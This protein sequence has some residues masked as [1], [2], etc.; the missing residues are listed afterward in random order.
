MTVVGEY[1][2]PSPELPQ[3]GV[4][5]FQADRAPGGLANVGH[6]VGR[7]DGVAPHQFGHRRR[8]GGLRVEE[9]AN[10]GSLEESN[11]P[12]IGMDIGGPAAGLKAGEGKA[13]VGRHVAV[14]AEQLA[15]GS[16]LLRL[17]G[18]ALADA[19]R[20]FEQGLVPP[21]AEG[22]ALVGLQGGDQ[23]EHDLG[24]L[25]RLVPDG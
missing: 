15:H 16:I 25:D 23:V 7:A 10:P 14:H 21:Q 5:I 1:P 19:D 11:A 17:H 20:Q 4:G 3:E 6:D 8:G 12:A 13:D 22:D 18:R 24:I 2:V 9:E